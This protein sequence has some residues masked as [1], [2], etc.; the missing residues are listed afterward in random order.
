MRFDLNDDDDMSITKFENMLESNEIGFFD[1]DEFEQIIEHYL[2]LG[3]MTLARKAIAMSIA[4]HPT[5]VHLRLFRAEMLIFDDKFDLAHALLN[6]LHEVEPDNAEI[7]VQKANIYSKT[8]QHQKA[9]QLLELAVDLT[10]D[11]ADIYNLI[12]MEY[13][14]IEDYYKAKSNFIK[15]LELDEADYSALYN[16]M[17]CFDFLNEQKKAIKFL[18]DY[19]NTNPYSEVAWHQLGKQYYDLKL[20][21]KALEA[22]DFAIIAD[23]SFIG[24]YLEKGKAL[25]KL[26]RY[27]EAIANYEFTLNLD[28]PTSFAYLRMGKCYLKLNNQEKAIHYFSKTVDEDPL[29]DKGWLAIVNFYC[30]RSEYRKALM[31]MEKAMEIDS[32]NA[33][34]WQKFAYINSSLGFYEEAEYGYKMALELGNYEL[35]TW[36]SRCDILL[37]LG[38]FDAVVSH[39]ENGLEFYPKD[40]QLEMR[41][42]GALITIGKPYEGLYYLKNVFSRDASHLDTFFNLFPRLKNKPSITTLI[43]SLR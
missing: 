37:K 25:E 19:L 22:F 31:Y 10:P 12:G 2:D 33:M 28:D 16:V 27:Y 34:Y 40:E 15:C 30:K 41:L 26:K 5:S 14:F 29:L 6:E 23:D 38:E 11:P 32:E 3:K 43:G 18:R 7:F 36:I 8:E 42:G 39:L 35:K 24:A 17:Y 21:E 1:S 9:I 13:L 20:Y 4:Q